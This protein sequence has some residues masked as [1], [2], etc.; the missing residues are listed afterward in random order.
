MKM[1]DGEIRQFDNENEQIDGGG[2][3]GSSCSCSGHAERIPTRAW[4]AA[5]VGG[6]FRR[7]GIG[8]GGQNIDESQL[9]SRNLQNWYGFI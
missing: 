6:Q 8:P 1:T 2:D 7:T 5:G 4:P 9:D 3:G